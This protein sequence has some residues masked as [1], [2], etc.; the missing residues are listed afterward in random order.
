MTP[1]EILIQNGNLNVATKDERQVTFSNVCCIKI[2]SI[3]VSMIA[4]LVS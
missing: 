1:P 4:Q 3:F 2:V